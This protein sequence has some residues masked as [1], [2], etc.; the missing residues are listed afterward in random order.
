ML[1]LG[2]Y[3]LPVVLSVILGVI[4]KA[5]GPDRLGDRWK[6]LIACAVGMGLGF[7][8]LIYNQMPWTPTNIIDGLLSG[9]MY[10]ASAVGLYEVSRTYNNP[11][12]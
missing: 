4:Y 6:P 1:S 9:F 12:S 2:K 7:V 8:V 5:I 11:R 3:A 10:G